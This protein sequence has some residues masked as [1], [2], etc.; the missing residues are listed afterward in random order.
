MFLQHEE[1]KKLIRVKRINEKE[2]RIK[3]EDKNGK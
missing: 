2:K 1:N 3:N